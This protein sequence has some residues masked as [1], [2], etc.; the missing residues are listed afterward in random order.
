MKLSTAILTGLVILAVVVGGGA[1]FLS[2]WELPAPT[3]EVER[4]I[5]DDRFS[6]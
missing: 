6:R 3:V 1:V 2:Y 5:P 4:V